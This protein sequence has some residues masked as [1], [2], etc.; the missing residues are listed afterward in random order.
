MVRAVAW[1]DPRPTPC[2]A[3]DLT[4]PR[5]SSCCCRHLAT[6]AYAV[7][8][9][10]TV[11]ER[12]MAS[13]PRRAGSSTP[14][15]TAH[16]PSTCRSLRWPTDPAEAAA[17]RRATSSRPSTTGS[18]WG[19]RTGLIPAISSPR[20][21]VTSKR[22][23]K[24]VMVALSVIGDP[25]LRATAAWRTFGCRTAHVQVKQRRPRCSH[26]PWTVA[27]SAFA[28]I[29]PSWAST[30]TNC[31]RRWATAG[32]TSRRCV[33]ALQWL[34]QSKKGD[35][36]NPCPSG[37]VRLRREARAAR[38]VLFE[39]PEAHC[40]TPRLTSWPDQRSGHRCPGRPRGGSVALHFRR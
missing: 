40:R 27:A 2:I 29:L 31:W 34:D 15:S 4:Q 3:G 17:I 19:T 32:A 6:R 39:N 33:T 38:A 23:F 21:S 5:R 11:L 30:P 35:K 22:T 8:R 9:R 37:R 7:A 26:S 28:W 20:P 36:K 24:P 13:R 25:H 14:P 16:R 12:D 18:F 1:T 10:R